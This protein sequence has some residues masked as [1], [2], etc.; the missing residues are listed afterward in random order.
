MHYYNKYIIRT[1]K[2]EY[3]IRIEICCNTVEF[4]ILKNFT[5]SGAHIEFK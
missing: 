3:C 4:V 5:F 1:F 2:V